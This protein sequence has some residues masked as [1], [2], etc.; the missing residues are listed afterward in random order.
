VSAPDP[1]YLATAIEVVTAA[2][3][4]QR[5][6]FGSEFRVDKKGTI[7]LVTEVDVEVEQA[8]RALLYARFPDHD[9]LAE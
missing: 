1:R 2:G 7:D 5:A 6:R 8:A 9:I 3:A 4:I